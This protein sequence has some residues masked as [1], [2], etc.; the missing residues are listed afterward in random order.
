MLGV[1]G[2]QCYVR[3]HGAF[4]TFDRFQTLRNNMQQVASNN[5][6]SCWPTMLRPFASSLKSL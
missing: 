5:V 4:K 6:G 1:V 3:M 2:Q